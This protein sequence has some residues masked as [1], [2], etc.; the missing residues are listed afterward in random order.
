MYFKTFISHNTIIILILKLYVKYFY[1][2]T[3]KII[4]VKGDYMSKFSERL[5]ELRTERKLTQDRLA[6]LTGINQASISA[7]ELKKIRPTDFVIVTFCKFF[8]VSADFIL[9]LKD[10]P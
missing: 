4:F 2:Y 9:G 1:K 10:E 7:Y 3:S 5:K 8:N 6:E